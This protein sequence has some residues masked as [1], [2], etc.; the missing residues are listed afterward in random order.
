MYLCIYLELSCDVCFFS[1]LPP[2]IAGLLNSSE[3][4]RWTSRLLAGAK[5]RHG[6]WPE[7]PPVRC[8]VAQPV[9][10]DQLLT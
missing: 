8:A 6:Q 5:V 4:V 10:V 1:V 7:G 3:R 2:F 9:S